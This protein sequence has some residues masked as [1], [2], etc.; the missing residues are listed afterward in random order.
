MAGNIIPAI[1]TTNAMTA[2]LCVMQALKVIREAY[3]KARTVFLVKSTE[4]ATNAE[5]LKPPKPD[6]AV[7]GVSLSRVEADLSRATLEDL[8][9][10]VL[11]KQL[12]YGQEISVRSGERVLY[13]QDLDDNLTKMLSDMNLKQYSFLTV[14]DEADEDTRVDLVL[15][16]SEKTIPS[17]PKPI[18]LT[19]KIEIVRKIKPAPSAPDEDGIAH[20][21]TNGAVGKR[22]RDADDAELETDIVAKRGKVLEEDPSK[23]AADD[24]VVLLNDN[25]DSAIVID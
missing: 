12:G 16:I 10:G 9:D 20:A 1:A 19:E 13:D 18:F 17:D 11:R 25:T 3:D 8:V 24:D 5:P 22:K 14:V 2:G 4:R 15:S 7:C 21:S 6:C 23:P